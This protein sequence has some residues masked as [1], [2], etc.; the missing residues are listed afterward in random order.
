MGFNIYFSS[1]SGSMGSE[2]ISG[3]SAFLRTNRARFTD[4]PPLKFMIGISF[5]DSSVN[6]LTL[7]DSI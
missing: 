2:V 4:L 6:P 3:K 1:T 5:Y 7:I